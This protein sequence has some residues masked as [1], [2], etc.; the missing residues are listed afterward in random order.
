[1]LYFVAYFRMKKKNTE[2]KR[3]KWKKIRMK[4]RSIE[5]ERNFSGFRSKYLQN[6]HAL[7]PQ[8]LVEITFPCFVFL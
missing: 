3:E 8:S 5:K 6:F 4:W 7:V 1:M 2:K